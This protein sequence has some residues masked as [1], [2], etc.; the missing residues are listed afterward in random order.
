M[1]IIVIMV[2]MI[3]MVI[4]APMFIIVKIVKGL[5]VTKWSNFSQ[6]VQIL[7]KIKNLKSEN[8]WTELFDNFRLDHF[9]ND[10][11]N[12]LILNGQI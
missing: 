1:V 5:N 4:M 11:K 10:E 2:I 8:L 6:N 7:I 9:I 12:H 3:F